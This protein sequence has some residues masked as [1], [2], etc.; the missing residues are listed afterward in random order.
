MLKVKDLDVLF[1]H[2]KNF[3]ITQ[4]YIKMPS[5][6]FC[7][8]SSILNECRFTNE[9]IDFNIENTDILKV[10]NYLNKY[11]PKIVLIYGT[12][13][14]HINA[15]EIAKI[16]KKV[17]KN[18]LVGINGM[19][20][21]FIDKYILEKYE[22]IDFVLKHE[23]DFV[24]KQILEYECNLN[25]CHNIKNLS[26]KNE[27]NSILQNENINDYN[28]QTIPVGNRNLYNLEKYYKYNSESIVRSSRGCPSNCDFCNKR[29]YLKFKIFSMKY[30][31]SE[32]NQLI[33]KG[34]ESFFFSDDTF[35]FSQARLNE[36]CEC[37]SKG[38]YTFRWTSNLR[39][40]D[41]TEELIATMKK[42]GAY[43]VFIGIET[44]NINSN[45]LVNK[46]QNNLNIEEKINILKKYNMEYHASFIVGNPGDTKEDLEKTIEFVKNA[47][48]TLATFNILRLFPGTN[49]FNT[50]EKYGLI[51]K[52]KF[53]FEN[54]EWITRP[55]VETKNLTETDI[56]YYARKMMKEMITCD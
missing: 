10:E 18:S 40:S 44:I 24:L 39:L 21:T 11:S 30:F 52:D 37:Y 55:L 19:I 42:H 53:W 22:F 16:S 34:F 25:L 12:S 38:N 7:V 35:A 6:E 56:I 23:A 27:N 51:M 33:K 50:P 45:L 28:I 48:P 17:F 5:L 29:I 47:K 2:P 31:F 43:R 54:P 20:V 1:I 32:I 41:I 49:I 13:H 15:I 46:S 26:Y 3:S 14:N 9:L 36:F 8:M 4:G